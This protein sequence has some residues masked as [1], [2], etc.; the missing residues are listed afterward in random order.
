MTNATIT[1]TSTT[2][3]LTTLLIAN[4][5][6]DALISVGYTVFD[7]YTSGSTEVRV[8]ALNLSGATKGTVYLQVTVG[9]NG[10]MST[11]LHE[12]WNTTS[13]TGTNSLASNG[14]ATSNN[15]TA[16]YFYAVNH[17]EFKGLVL[18]QGA[19][20]NV[21]GILR[22]KVNP[23]NWWNENIYPY[24]F[25]ARYNATPSSSRFSATSTPF[26]NLLDHEYLQNSKLQD[27]NAQNSD[28]RSILPL[29]ILSGGLGGILAACDD[30]IICASNTIRP[31]DT[32]TVAANEIY[33][34]IWG[35]ALNSGIAI[36]TT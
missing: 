32:I 3:T 22:P 26:G 17:P 27:G 23:P 12:A 8:M 2:G 18:E 10:S 31:Q 19:M 7:S 28:A 34:Y 9:S 1:K 4:Y 11:T 15:T 14:I 36:R 29:C 30:V 35:T 25:F 6:R 16:I 13:R 5:V 33:T 21:I 24:A 20:Q